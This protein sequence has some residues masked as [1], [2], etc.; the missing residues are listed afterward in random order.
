[1]ISEFD[2]QP[3]PSCEDEIQTGLLSVEAALEKILLMITPIA[4]AELV[5]VQESLGRVL[6]EDLYSPIDVPNHTNA[7]MDGY[8]VHSSDLEKQKLCIIGTAWAG[9]PFNEPLKRGECVRIMTGAVMPQNSDTVV[10][11]EHVERKDDIIYLASG[12]QPRQ[13]VRQA[14]EDLNIGSLALSARQRLF[15][16][17]LGVIASLGIAE[18]PVIKKPRVAFF[19][20]GDELRSINETLAIGEVYDSNRY[21][22]NAMLTRAGA[23]ILDLG[24]V[25]DNP[26]RLEETFQQA[27]ANADLVITSAG[28][29]VGD[30][31]YVLDI[32][33][34]IGEVGF[35]KIAMKPGRPLSV[36][37]IGSSTFFGLPGNPVSVMVTF[38]QFVLPALRKLSGEKNIAKFRCSARLTR[39]LKKRRG[40]TEFQ[41]GILKLGDDGTLIVENTGEQGSGI[42]T[43]MNQANCFVILPAECEGAN[44]GDIVIV[45][46]FSGLI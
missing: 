30:A 10:M 23:S 14:G 9:R 26:K 45:E 16:A 7:A 37:E 13:H 27:A 6:A 2:I 19:S 18:V 15:P 32:L 44:V 17:E 29:S 33:K 36:G 1:M 35:W 24:V 42:L 34:K 28:A 4:E 38:Y 22:L 3:Q 43:S 46:P 21:T 25:P 40:R 31:D 20:N 8:A 5:P 39:N 11:Q 12:Q 41:R